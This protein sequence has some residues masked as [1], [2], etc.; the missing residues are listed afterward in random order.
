MAQWIK[1]PALAQ[2]WPRSQ[3]KLWI[4]SLAGKLSYALSVAKKEKKK[5]IPCKFITNPKG[6]FNF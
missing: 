1:D 4:Q 5:T 3:L 2:L 6:I